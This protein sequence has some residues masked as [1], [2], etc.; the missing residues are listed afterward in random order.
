MGTRYGEDYA[1]LLEELDMWTNVQPAAAQAIRNLLTERDELRA[2]LGDTQETIMDNEMTYFE[3]F[4]KPLENRLNNGSA[5]VHIWTTEDVRHWDS[6]LTEDDAMEV[7]DYIM[8]TLDSNVGITWDVIEYA[9]SH[10]RQVRWQPL[11][12]F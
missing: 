2:Y 7:L 5:I 12:D 3:R 11:V 9:I 4:I 1:E 10:L 8:D 6:S